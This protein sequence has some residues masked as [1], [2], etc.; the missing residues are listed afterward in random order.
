M[1]IK[2]IPLKRKKIIVHNVAEMIYSYR[3]SKGLTQADLAEAI[4]SYTLGKSRVNIIQVYEKGLS[5]PDINNIYMLSK[6]L[7]IEKESFF[8]IVLRERYDIFTIKHHEKFLRA[9]RKKEKGEK[10][11]SEDLKCKYSFIKR[12]KIKYDFSKSSA[13]IKKAFLEKNISYKDLII[14]M[15]NHKNIQKEYCYSVISCAINGKKT[16]SLKTILDLCEFLEIKPFK[17][18][19]LMIQEKAF[20]HS[21]NMMKRWEL[22][23]KKMISKI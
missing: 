8:N 15:K 10:I 14:G 20:A 7:N 19:K 6:V 9:I 17:I 18:Y 4:G 5:L 16:T 13:M 22:H 2:G 11:S 12:G 1:N 3:L 21:K 23:K